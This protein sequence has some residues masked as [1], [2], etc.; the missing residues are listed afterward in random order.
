[1]KSLVEF[2]VQKIFIC[3]IIFSNGIITQSLEY[4]LHHMNKQVKPHLLLRPEIQ[5][6]KQIFCISNM[7]GRVDGWVF[8]HEN[9][10]GL[11]Q[12]LSDLRNPY[13]THCGENVYANGKLLD[14]M[15]KMVLKAP[16]NNHL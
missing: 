10:C 7:V 9:R 6:S 13:L 8:F 3:G 12:W 1:M 14:T 11:S 4:I 16:V 15:I 2:N 5:R